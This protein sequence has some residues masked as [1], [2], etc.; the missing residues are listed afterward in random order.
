MLSLR[1][2]AA[3]KR[4]AITYTD[5]ELRELLTKRMQQLRSNY[6]G[7]LEEIVHFLVVEPGDT[8]REVEAELGF[9]PL[10]NMERVCFGDP[11]FTP[12]WEWIQCHGRWFE[13]VYILTDDGFGSVIFIPNDPGTEFDLHSLCLE[14]ACCS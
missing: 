14:Y 9:S 8:P 2:A 12:D 10:I 5:N 3:M 1:T 7:D 4:A 11:D 6:D 13:L